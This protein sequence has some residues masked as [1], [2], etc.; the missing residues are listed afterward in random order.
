MNVFAFLLAGD[1]LLSPPSPPPFAGGGEIDKTDLL[2]CCD[3]IKRQGQRIWLLSDRNGKVK[4]QIKGVYVHG[5]VLLFLVQL[6]NRSPVDYTIDGV[7]FLPSG[8]GKSKT[9]RSAPL[10]PVYVYDS[11]KMVPANSRAASIF[12]LPRFTLPWGGKLWIDVQEKNGNRHLH[13][14]I[15]NWVLARARLI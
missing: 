4:L 9:A 7:S 8:S 3:K 15:N 11:T 10:E 1:G 2:A 13:I 5:S 14:P 6:N 12:V